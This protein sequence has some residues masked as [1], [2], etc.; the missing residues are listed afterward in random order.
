MPESQKCSI[1]NRELSWHN[2]QLKKHEG[3]KVCTKCAWNLAKG[4]MK[5]DRDKMK[6]AK[7]DPNSW[8]NKTQSVSKKLVRIGLS[9][10]LFLF[11]LFILPFGII[12]WFLAVYIASGVFRSTN[13]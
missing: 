10:L 2:T 7:S 9:G 6:E 8:I 3:K 5:E 12:L 11:G 4:K 13:K 1:C